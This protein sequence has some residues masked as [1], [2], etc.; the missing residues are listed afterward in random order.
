MREGKG[1]KTA[2]CRWKAAAKTLVVDASTWV[3]MPEA[4][5]LLE[6]LETFSNIAS[7]IEK[8]EF[9]SF[10]SFTD[11]LAGLADDPSSFPKCPNR[12]KHERTSPKLGVTHQT[13]SCSSVAPQ[14]Y[15][16]NTIPHNKTCH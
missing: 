15:Q 1:G 4:S 14:L 6:T 5:V 11:F 9:H 2:F 3:S 8:V 13:L 12:V 16:M 7:K 10:T